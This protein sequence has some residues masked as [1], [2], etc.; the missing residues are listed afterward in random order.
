MRQK[1]RGHLF[2]IRKLVK[3]LGGR[4]IRGR[5]LNIVTFFGHAKEMTDFDFSQGDVKLSATFLLAWMIGAFITL[6]IAF[7]ELVARMPPWVSL[8]L[9][10]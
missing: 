8:L 9:R 3:R 7:E 1:I 5:S 10:E 2:F 6:D 4:E